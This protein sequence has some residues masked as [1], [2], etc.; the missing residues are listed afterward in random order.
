MPEPGSGGEDPADASAFVDAI[1]RRD[2]ER[3]DVLGSSAALPGCDPKN[4][5][6]VLCLRF[7]N[8]LRDESSAMLAMSG[9]AAY[10]PGFDGV[11]LDG[12][13]SADLRSSGAAGL[14]LPRFTLEAWVRPNA[15][16]SAEPQGLVSLESVATLSMT[17][18]G[19]LVCQVEDA[20]QTGV[21]SK[22]AS[23]T[24]RPLTWRAVACVY[25]GQ[26]LA[27]Y[28]DG[29]VVGSRSVQGF[30]P[31]AQSSHAQVGGVASTG[32][33]DGLLDNVRIWSRRLTPSELCASA[34]SCVM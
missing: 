2:A 33:F 21:E 12:A 23:H 32:R 1:A 27:I 16:P 17:S 3:T 8:D 20:Q 22:L 26:E 28:V 34:P 5:D 13:A 29:F 25:N 7:E 10:A 14:V 24:V 9:Q 30:R 19:S 4:P 11:A 18:E 6:L 31:T 15:L